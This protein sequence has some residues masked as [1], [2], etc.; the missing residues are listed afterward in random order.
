MP[1]GSQSKVFEFLDSLAIEYSVQSHRAVFT[2]EDMESLEMEH[3]DRVAKNLFVRDD[4]KE[5]YYLVVI[6]KDKTAN[7]KDL[8]HKIGSRRL[9]FASENDL[10]KYLGLKKGEVSPFGALNDEANAVKI[11]ID[12]DLAG[13]EFIGVHP[14]DNTATVWISAG[15]LVAALGCIGH[16]ASY[17]RL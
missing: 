4:K 10:D 3:I 16:K 1:E 12:E 2:I 17:M 11:I 7:L 15:N 6:A 13:Y 14:N 8:Q 5:H 9:S